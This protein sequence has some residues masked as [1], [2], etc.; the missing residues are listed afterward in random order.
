MVQVLVNLHEL[1]QVGE[2]LFESLLL[3]LFIRQRYLEVRLMKPPEKR[4]I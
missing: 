4:M 3:I 1:V 2:S